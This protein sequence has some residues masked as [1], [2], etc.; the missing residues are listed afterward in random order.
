M[1]QKMH[2]KIPLFNLFN[3]FEYYLNSRPSTLIRLGGKQIHY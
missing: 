2:M 1:T 3:S